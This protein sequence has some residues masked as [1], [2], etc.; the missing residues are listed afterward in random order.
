[1]ASC[2]D[3]LDKL[4]VF[5]D[6]ELDPAERREVEAHLSLCPPCRE[7]FRIEYNVLRQVR[8]KCRETSAPPDLLARVKQVCAEDAAKAGGSAE[9]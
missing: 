4:Y 1:M 2:Q 8:E 5:L 9:G 6:R 7:V 3:T